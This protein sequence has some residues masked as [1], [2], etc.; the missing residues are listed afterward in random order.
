MRLLPMLVVLVA[1]AGCGN[2]SNPPLPEF[3]FEVKAESDPGVPVG[4]VTITRSGKEVGTTDATG[5]AT[6]TFKGA[7]GDSFDLYIK[8]PTDYSSPMTPTS[9][10]LSRLADGK[11]M[12]GTVR[13]SPSKRKV[14]IAVRAEGGP[15]LPVMY[16]NREVAR[17]DGAGAAHFF[18]TGKP[19][20]QLQFTLDTSDKSNELLQPQNPNLTVLVKDQDDVYVVDQPFQK[21]RTIVRVIPRTVIHNGPRP[22]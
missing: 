16:F 7:E 21:R 1:S 14:V 3:K 11:I 17:T 9:V 15:N 18:V 19:G 20:E 2:V 5:K 12:S 10:R 4:G 8:C 22:L 6:L 13:C